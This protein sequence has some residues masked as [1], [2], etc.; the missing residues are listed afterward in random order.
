MADF[1]QK[2]YEFRKKYR[3]GVRQKKGK[4]Y[5]NLWKHLIFAKGV[6]KTW[7]PLMD[8]SNLEN[9]LTGHPPALSELAYLHTLTLTPT[10]I[11]TQRGTHLNTDS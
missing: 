3:V 8:P 6:D 4:K 2:C 9:I 10:H 5:S 7:T 1:S 11:Q